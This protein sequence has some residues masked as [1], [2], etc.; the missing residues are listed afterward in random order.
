MKNIEDETD[1][2]KSIGL[3]SS[4]PLPG[5]GQ[6]VRDAMLHVS[7]CVGRRRHQ[8]VAFFCAGLERMHK[9][10]FAKR[11]MKNSRLRS[12]AGGKKSMVFLSVTQEVR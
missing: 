6:Q 4:P 7:P 1:Q 9:R 11:V 3:L 5:K 2:R 12:G 10:S 8:R